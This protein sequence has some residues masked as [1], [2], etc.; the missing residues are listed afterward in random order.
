[1]YDST[2]TFFWRG[3]HDP[4]SPRGGTYNRTHFHCKIVTAVPL[5]ALRDKQKTPMNTTLG[6][7]NAMSFATG[8]R[9]QEQRK[10]KATTYVQTRPGTYLV[11]TWQLTPW[12]LILEI[13]HLRGGRC[14]VRDISN[15]KNPYK[16]IRT[17]YDTYITCSLSS[18]SEWLVYR[19][20]LPLLP[21]TSRHFYVTAKNPGGR[22]RTI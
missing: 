17:N 2:I 1:M 21:V 22:A 8:M 11:R 18:V 7:K 19:P 16:T 12:E 14:P 15:K 20:L 10:K 6:D 5:N 13:G 9:P 3:A 4:R